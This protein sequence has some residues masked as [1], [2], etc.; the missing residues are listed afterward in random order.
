MNKKTFVKDIKQIIENITIKDRSRNSNSQSQ[1]Y[2]INRYNT[3]IEI[4]IYK[5]SIIKS[6]I[7]S[8]MK[9][10]IETFNELNMLS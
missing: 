5:K 7:K 1:Y 10:E 3:I 6:I 2:Q 9:I 8:N 4:N